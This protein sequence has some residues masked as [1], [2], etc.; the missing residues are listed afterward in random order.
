[1]EVVAKNTRSGHA[2][3]AIPIAYASAKA[4][5]A[6][7]RWC[8]R[9]SQHAAGLGEDGERE[10][11]SEKGAVP[12]AR[13]LRHARAPQQRER[14]E[15]GLHRV[16]QH[17]PVVEEREGREQIHERRDQRR[18][19]VVQAPRRR[20]DARERQRAEQERHEASRREVATARPREQQRVHVD[21][22]A[23]AEQPG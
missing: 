6:R 21:V 16:G 13:V 3:S 17:E 10:Q 23:L 2:T 11:Q 5:A 1:V 14:G 20:E 18:A 7:A 8:A 15:R 22:D 19:V 9:S 4:R 12:G